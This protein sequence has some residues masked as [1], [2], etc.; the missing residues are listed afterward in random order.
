MTPRPGIDPSLRDSFELLSFS[1]D[2]HEKPIRR[3][4]RRSGQTYTV[5]LGV[6]VGEDAE[7]VR[8]RHAYR[9]IVS[10]AGHFFFIEVPQPCHNLSLRLDY[11]A[12]DVERVSVMDLVSSSQR[13]QVSRLPEQAGAKAIDVDLPG[14][15]L[16]RAGF[17]VV[18]TLLSES[19]PASS[20]A[21]RAA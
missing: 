6:E 1:V 12:A 3:S 8:I 9:T 17:T 13:S 2:G 21:T 11:T 14:W 15:L 7:P 19:G 16:P 4:A 5:H 20:A 10:Q 18:W